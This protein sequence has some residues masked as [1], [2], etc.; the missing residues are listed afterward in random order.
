MN[1]ENKREPHRGYGIS[2]FRTFRFETKVLIPARGK[3]LVKVRWK[4]SHPGMEF[5]KL[6]VGKSR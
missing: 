5:G 2:I 1:T 6:D 4:I 3:T